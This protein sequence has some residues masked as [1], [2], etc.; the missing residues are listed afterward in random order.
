MIG[1]ARPAVAR[2]IRTLDDVHEAMAHY[3][4]SLPYAAMVAM[5]TGISTDI[6]YRL[7]SD[8]EMAQALARRASAGRPER[9]IYAAYIGELLLRG[10]E[11]EGHRVVFQFSV[12]AEPLPQETMSRVSQHTLAQISELVARHPR[13]RFQGFVASRHAHQSFCTMARELPNFSLAGYWWHNFFPGAIRQTMEER[14]DMVPANKQ[15]G[16]FSDAYCV[17]WAYAKAGIVRLQMAEV[18]SGKIAQGQYSR[19]DA[20]DIARQ[21]LSETPQTLLGMRPGPAAACSSH[22]RSAAPSPP[23]QMMSLPPATP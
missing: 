10:L 22:G 19:A 2:T 12:G 13:L 5:A 8:T 16:F 3:L 9:D 6:D 4:A 7:P 11:R 20:V 18:Y 1:A 17:E 21:V 14:L 15:C 23:G